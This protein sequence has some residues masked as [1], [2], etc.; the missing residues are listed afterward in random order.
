MAMIMD[1]QVCGAHH[2]QLHYQ[3]EWEEAFPTS[4]ASD[5]DEAPSDVQHRTNKMKRMRLQD[6]TCTAEKKGQ[7]SDWEE[8][9]LIRRHKE[10][11]NKWATISKYLPGRSDN[12]VKNHWN[13]TLRSKSASRHRTFLWIYAKQVEPIADSKESRCK[14]FKNS[15][16]EYMAII[17][18]FGPAESG[19]AG[20]A[21]SPEQDAVV[22]LEAEDMP[23]A[24]KRQYRDSSDSSQIPMYVEP[25]YTP[26]S[27]M[28]CP[29]ILGH[30]SCSQLDGSVFSE[31]DDIP[32]LP[33]ANLKPVHTTYASEMKPL[34]TSSSSTATFYA[35]Q[36]RRM[37][38]PFVPMRAPS[39]SV[40]IRTDNSFKYGLTDVLP[41]HTVQLDGSNLNRSSS[42]NDIY[43]A[44]GSEDVAMSEGLLNQVPVTRK[45]TDH[46]LQFSSLSGDFSGEDGSCGEEDGVDPHLIL[47]GAP[48][49]TASPE[50][51][52]DEG[53]RLAEGLLNPSPSSS[54]GVDPLS[55]SY[56]GCGNGY[57][58]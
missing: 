22:P 58:F 3:P 28:P 16:A 57:Y 52:Q 21:S 45:S 13:S 51:Y 18:K 10:I 24:A 31:E 27:Q 41:A 20:E 23:A 19:Q 42:F 43:Q 12:G 9:E 17:E 35:V 55:L 44:W 50:S 32:L 46:Q 2:E 6:D 54:F 56:P 29:P 38:A 33:L 53:Y 14:V 30:N 40:S 5:C 11:G 26:R 8:L 7:W 1:N 15:R 4:S 49:A 37:D 25:E 39:T 36:E 48:L 34:M 47:F